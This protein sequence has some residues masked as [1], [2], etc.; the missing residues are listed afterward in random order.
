VIYKN[1]LLKY[2]KALENFHIV[3]GDKYHRPDKFI[4]LP[5]AKEDFNILLIPLMLR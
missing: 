2:K 1:R 3:A 5:P 4:T